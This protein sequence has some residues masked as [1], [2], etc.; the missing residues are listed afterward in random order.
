MNELEHT[1]NPTANP[2]SQQKTDPTMLINNQLANSLPLTQLNP[3]VHPYLL[4]TAKDLHLYE[5][6][7][8]NATSGI[9]SLS[10]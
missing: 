5:Q 9:G 6:T 1:D 2:P 4:P 10:I 8:L 3:N 7:Q